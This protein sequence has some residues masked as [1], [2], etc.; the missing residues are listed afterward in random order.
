MVVLGT[1]NLGSTQTAGAGDL[2]TLGAVPHGVADRHLHGAAE[3]RAALQLSADVL[4]HELGIQVGLADLNDLE[5]DGHTRHL[6]Q[7]L[8]VVVDL[9]AAL[10]DD[11]ARLS[12][13]DEHAHAARVTL[14][15]DL[16]DTGILQRLLQ[17]LADLVVGHEG[18]AEVLLT[19]VPSGVPVLDDTHAHAVGI[20]FLSH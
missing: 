16:G 10:A 14:D 1:C 18:V 2:D 9:A 15:L 5:R 7:L 12:A 17:V 13:V 19:C 4:C 11:H 20:D 6:L 3:G 8:L